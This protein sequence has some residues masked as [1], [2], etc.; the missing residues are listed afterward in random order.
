M[1][2]NDEA[3]ANQAQFTIQDVLAIMERMK[4]DNLEAV[5]TL[6]AELR[7]PTQAELDK[8]EKER[9][10]QI[11]NA[12]AEAEQARLD[13]KCRNGQ[14]EYCT[15]MKPDKSTRWGGQVGSDGC[16][17]F[18]CNNCRDILPPV[19]A[20]M[21]WIQNGVNCHSPEDVAG[22]MR[23]ITKDQIIGWHK[24]DIAAGRQGPCECKYCVPAKP[25]LPVEAQA[26]T[27]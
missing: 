15:H 6:A 16:V 27:A 1:A 22:A 20:P 12:R 24:A 7:K 8:A 2:K 11:R 26:A 10:Q 9:Q 14:K 17:R 3:V 25:V 13:E 5:K 21:E 23:F 18:F 4:A 19:K